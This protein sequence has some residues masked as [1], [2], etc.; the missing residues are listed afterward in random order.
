ML[1]ADQDQNFSSPLNIEFQ[2][3]NTFENLENGAV[4]PKGQMLYF[5]YYFHIHYNFS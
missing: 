4:A 2:V 3:L 5:P 1:P